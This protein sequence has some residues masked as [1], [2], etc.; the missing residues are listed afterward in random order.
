MKRGS[1][2]LS[3]CIL[4]LNS[5]VAKAQQDSIWTLEECIAYA[6]EQNITIRKT[7]LSNQSLEYQAAQTK[8][9]RFPALSASVNQNFSLNRSSSLDDAGNTVYGKG[10]DAGNN[11]GFSINSSVTLFNASRLNNEIK[12]AKLDII[13]GKYN[14]ET[15]QESVSLSILEAF[16]QI[17]YAREAVKNSEKQIESTTEQVRLA[18]E[19]LNLRAISKAEYSEYAAELANEKLTL[20]NAKSNLAISKLNLMQLMELPV[21]DNFEIDLP[22]LVAT[23]NQSRKPDINA[24]YE[25]ALSIKPQIKGAAIEKEIAMLDE[26]IAKSDYYP[27]LSAHAGVNTGYSGQSYGSYFNQLDRGLN[28]SVSLS[29]SIPIYQQRSIKTNIATAKINYQTAELDEINTKNALRK[30]IEQACFDVESAQTEY[31]ASLENYNYTHESFALSEEKF[32]QG[33][34]NSVDFLVSK[35]KLIEAESGLLQSKFNLIFCYKI[36]DFYMGIPLTL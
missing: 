13:G 10:F 25:K 24:S 22:E 30:N 18:G 23:L 36:L 32:R 8:A 15:T 20:A 9:Q 7:G 6:L 2:I 16:L 4:L 33:S 35:T 11:S 14:L 1:I 34:I 12:Q 31:E 17:L 27:S 26:K 5:K 19:R 29:L 21:T 3:L 28:P